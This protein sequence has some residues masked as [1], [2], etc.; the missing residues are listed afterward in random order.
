MAKRSYHSLDDFLATHPLTVDGQGND[1]GDVHY[2][3]KGVEIDA[4][5]LFCDISNFSG[6]TFN[7]SP[8]ETLAFVNHF[9][10]WISEEALHGRPGIVDK[11]IGDEIM[12]VFSSAFGSDDPFLDAVKTARNMINHDPWAFEPHI[13][14]ASGPV[15]VGYVGTPIKYNCSVFGQCV[16][17]AARCAG[18]KPDPQ[19]F[20][21]VSLLSR[22]PTGANET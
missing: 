22:Q 17:T 18:I 4:T 16:A 8:T 12:V 3:I 10:T 5:V 20:T 19:A 6:R 9:F 11:Y 21:G 2:P 1:G 14:I 13:G 7:L 15:T